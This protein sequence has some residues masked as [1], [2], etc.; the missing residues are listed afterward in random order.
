[1]LLKGAGEDLRLIARLQRGHFQRIRGIV[2]KSSCETVALNV[3]LMEWEVP[4]GVVRRPKVDRPRT[5]R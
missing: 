1:M 2:A 5:A 3:Q 4:S